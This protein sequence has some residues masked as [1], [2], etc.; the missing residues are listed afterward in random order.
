MQVP[1][2]SGDPAPT[3][4]PLCHPLPGGAPRM[5]G[6]P[7]PPWWW[8]WHPRPRT[9]LTGLYSGSHSGMLRLLISEAIF[10]LCPGLVTPMAVRSWGREGGGGQRRPA[11]PV[12]RSP[13]HRPVPASLWPHLRRHSADGGDVV[14]G[15]DEVR[16][17]ELQ[18]ELAEPLVHGLRALEEGWRGSGQPWGQGHATH[19]P[20]GCPHRMAGVGR[21]LCGSSSPV[22][23]GQAGWE[24]APQSGCVAPWFC[25]H[26]TRLSPGDS[27]RGAGAWERGS[28]P[29]QGQLTAPAHGTAPHRHRHHGRHPEPCQP[30]WPW[31][32]AAAVPTAVGVGSCPPT[33]HPPR[34][35]SPPT[36]APSSSAGARRGAAGRTGSW[37]RSATATNLP[38]RQR[39][40]GLGS[41]APGLR[42][43][44]VGGGG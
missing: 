27:M 33:R 34:S 21:D 44:E 13:R 36:A 3:L 22:P 23:A 11:P 17:V 19:V 2:G 12:P 20:R 10:F 35:P 25:P 18:L 42:P 14:A 9:A 6:S 8:L 30:R 26:G 31:H 41:R 29:P 7:A 43:S 24:L 39:S 32:R 4:T 28:R 15:V 16:R 5:A 40:A 38:E 1:L 37:P